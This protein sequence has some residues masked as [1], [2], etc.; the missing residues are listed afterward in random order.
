MFYEDLWLDQTGP[1]DCYM[2]VHLVRD[3][4]SYWEL[5][6]EAVAKICLLCDTRLSNKLSFSEFALS[7]YFG[8]RARRGEPL[9]VVLPRKLYDEVNQQN[10]DRVS[11]TVAEPDQNQVQDPEAP[12]AHAL[13]APQVFSQARPYE[14]MTT[15]RDEFDR[16]SSPRSPPTNRTVVRSKALLPTADPTQTFATTSERAVEIDNSRGELHSRSRRRIAVD[17]AI[18][19]SAALEDTTSISQSGTVLANQSLDSTYERGRTIATSSLDDLQER[20]T[21]TQIV[22][23]ILSSS[24]TLQLH[25]TSTNNQPAPST[26]TPKPLSSQDLLANRLNGYFF[27]GTSPR[28][29]YTDAEIHEVSMLLGLFNPRWGRVPRTYI[30]LRTISSLDILDR[31]VDIGFS[32]YWFPVTERSLPDFV[33]PSIRKAFVD[34]QK[35]ILTK[36]MDLE[37]GE[38]GRH[39]YFQRGES[40]PFEMKGI[41][42]SGGYGQ[43]DKVLSLISFKHYARKRVLRSFTF[44]GRKK[45]DIKQFISEIEILKRLKHRHVVEFVGSYTDAKYIGLIMTPIAEGDLGSYMARATPAEHAELRTFF[46]CLATALEFLHANSVRHKDIKPANILVS[47]SQI[48]FADFGLSLD[49]TDATG[50][51]TMSMVNGMTPRY[52]A[53]KVANYEA[54]NTM[55]DIW[56]LGIVFL[57]MIVTLKGETTEYMD[58]FFRGHGSQQ[59]FI[60]LNAAALPDFIAHLT[61]LP[62]WTDNRA[63]DWTAPMLQEVQ[64]MRPTASALVTQI[65]S[66]TREGE[67][68]GFCGICCMGPEGEDDG[69]G[70]SDYLSD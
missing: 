28:E 52:C 48:L 60:R 17:P 53:P 63:L 30:I 36:S 50:S 59:T 62:Q 13:S 14:N 43:V 41:L 70:F 61:S 2:S 24:R 5:Q 7:M 69:D 34:A 46:G 35:L 65:T 47:K 10:N 6:E 37:K 54:R 22:S 1:L 4:L 45:E 16:L 49:F 31:C 33:R 15:E 19:S 18:R 8:K 64:A 11:L 29:H 66:S 32:D 12:L 27:E 40:L 25:R 42:G 55:S 68:T 67:K 51:T 3:I 39:C 44:R 56:C 21:S 26:F 58:N 57:E 20:P 38:Q 23:D 9:P